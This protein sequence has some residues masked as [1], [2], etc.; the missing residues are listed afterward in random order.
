MKISDNMLSIL[1]GESILQHD[2]PA[3][4]RDILDAGWEVGPAGSLLLVALHGEGWRKDWSDEDVA[5]HEWEVNDVGVPSDGVPRKRDVF[6]AA[7]ASRALSFARIA[8]SLANEIDACRHLVAAVSVSDTEDYII[9]GT[10][11][12][13]FTRRG[14]Y[15]RYFESVS[16]TRLDAVALLYAEDVL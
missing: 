10:T 4:L 15:P 5:K 9:G 6:Q 2:L 14:S 8:M 12:H 3:K 11:V 13:F 1:T 16:G 7:M